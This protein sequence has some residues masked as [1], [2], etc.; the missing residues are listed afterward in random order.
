MP[1]APPILPTQVGS[2]GLLGGIVGGLLD[3]QR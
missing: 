3:N 2:G 1:A